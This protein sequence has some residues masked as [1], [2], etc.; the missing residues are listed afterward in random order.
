[1][2]G[3]FYPFFLHNVFMG[4]AP[5]FS[6]FFY[7]ILRHYKLHALHLHPN[8]ILLLS[9]FAFYCEAFV[10]VAPSVALLCHFFYL[11]MGSTQC[12]GCVYFVASHG[13]NAISRA[14]KKVEDFRHKWIFMDAKR[15]HAGLEL[16][17]AFPVKLDRWAHEK[18]TDPR[19]ERLLEKMT[20]DLEAEKLTGAMLVREF[21][22]QR[23]APLQAH[24]RPY[25]DSRARK[26]T[27]GYARTTCPMRS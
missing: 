15:S 27:S 25:G 19:A 21:L 11:R 17:T 10:G 24:S 1:M 23:L 5:P 22:T 13:S 3:T 16:L 18:L 12:S 4:L 2:G 7:A 26:T 6:N 8:S 20:A 9:I 14:G